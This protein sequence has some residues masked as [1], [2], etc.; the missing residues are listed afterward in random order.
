MI[1]IVYESYHS[2]TPKRGYWDH[3]LLDAVFDREIWRPVFAN[4]FVRRDGFAELPNDAE[5]AVIVLPARY[6]ANDVDKLNADIARL[7]WAVI[8]LVGDEAAE[9]PSEKIVHPNMIIWVMTPH[10][11]KHESAD[12]LLVNGWPPKTRELLRQYK[13]EADERPLDWFFAGQVT[14]S[15]RK[16]CVKQLKKMPE[17]L[18]GKLIETPG[19]TQG[20]PHEEYFKLM[21]SAKVVPCPSGAV[22]PDSFRVYEALEAGCLPIVDGLSPTGGSRGYWPFLLDEDNLPFPVIENWDD[23][24]GH[25]QYHT[26]VWPK[27]NNKAFAWWQNFKRNMVYNL[28]DD[29]NRL[30]GV[31]PEAKTVDEN[32]TVLIPT[33]PIPSHPSLRIIGET[34]ATVR[35]KLPNAEIIIMIDGVREQQMERYP[36]YAEYTR[37]I[38]WKCNN[39]WSNVLPVVFQEHR[40]QASMTK[41]VMKLVRTPTVFFVEHDTP[42]LAD[43]T[44]PFE[45]MV[46]AIVSKKAN[47]IRLHHEESILKEHRHLML[48]ASSEDVA[49]VPMMRTAQ[50]SQRPH[51]ASSEFYRTILQEYFTEDSRTMIEDK[52]H[53]VL[54]SA[55]TSRRRIGWNNFKVWMYTPE[56]G[57]KRSTTN[58]GRENDPKYEMKF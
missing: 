47:M 30:R 7:K 22:I 37:Q 50:W 52:M 42:L 48:D 11:D 44:I 55:Y 34:M 38:L 39:E 31:R 10:I 19:F 16:K 21:A 3:G 28:E 9:F 53:S 25:T 12:R 56:G 15:R 20:V 29:I 51:L 4:E 18:N 5:G 54:D 32:I 43:R 2:E 24:P 36:D 35:E 14:H 23:L 27:S 45:G 46:K 57:L 58:D 17:H 8:M 6:H 1:D 41:E 26:D 13:T 33:S 40:H 49:G